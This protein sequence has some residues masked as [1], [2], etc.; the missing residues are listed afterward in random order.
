MAPLFTGFHFGFGKG[1]AGTTGP[2]A[3][4]TG[5]SVADGIPD[6]SYLY[7]VFHGETASPALTFTVNEALTGCEIV[8]IG[9][10]GGGGSGHA[11]GGGAGGVVYAPGVDIPPGQYS[12][13]IGEGGL[14]AEGPTTYNVSPQTTGGSTSLGSPGEFYILAGGGGRGGGWKDGGDPAQYVNSGTSGADGGSGGG[15]TG[16]PTDT[17]FYGG[18]GDVNNNPTEERWGGQANQWAHDGGTCNNGP[19]SRGGAGG[20]G[21]AR[22]GQN[23]EKGG[24]GHNPNPTQQPTIG[25]GAPIRGSN[26][27]TTN[28]TSGSGPYFM[29]EPPFSPTGAVWPAIAGDPDAPGSTGAFGGHGVKLPSFPAP[30]VSPAFPDSNDPNPNSPTNG[31][32]ADFESQVGPE[33]FFGGGGGGAPHGNNNPGTPRYGGMGGIGGGGE[34]GSHNNDPYGPGTPGTFGTGSGGGGGGSQGDA[35]GEGAD[36]IIIIRIPA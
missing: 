24:P 23:I 27:S 35:G 25:P 30:V 16:D 22:S 19:A 7:Y 4:A 1:P 3:K 26:K 12:V 17:T 15:A 6:G 31:M 36:G 13:T 20:G 5:G 2:T 32:D 34:G 8:C 18:E 14:L 9:G 10:G 29:T 11:G 28:G 33:G 21:A